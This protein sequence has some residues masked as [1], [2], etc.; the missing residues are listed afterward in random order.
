MATKKQVENLCM[1]YSIMAG[2]PA[3]RIDLDVLRRYRREQS[4]IN[5]EDLL[6]GC[7]NVACV[8]G[9][10]S[11]HPYFQ[12]QGLRYETSGMVTLN[13]RAVLWD[14][15][16]ELFGTGIIFSAAYQHPAAQKHEALERIRYA[17]LRVGAITPERDDELAQE[18]KEMTC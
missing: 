16:C 3:E 8:G 13:R 15:S 5:D 11:A 18:E 4:I 10:L 9:W 17:L 12:A 1:A 2:I 14:V 6:Q 7:G